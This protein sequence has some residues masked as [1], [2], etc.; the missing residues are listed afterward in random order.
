MHINIFFR[1]DAHH[2]RL[3]RMTWPPISAQ[4]G[5]ESYW[6]R[7]CVRNILSIFM[8]S[9]SWNFVGNPR[10]FLGASGGRLV[11]ASACLWSTCLWYFALLSKTLVFA[12]F[13]CNISCVVA[14]YPQKMCNHK[15]VVI[16]TVLF[17]SKMKKPSEK[18]VKSVNFGASHFQAFPF[19]GSTGNK[20]TP[21]ETPKQNLISCQRNAKP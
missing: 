17:L 18:C 15:N 8:E 1:A 21:L 10:F 4:G 13:L 12:V 14:L 3:L 11:P 19:I 6:I 2:R 20:F 16:D 7:T 9:W 5:L